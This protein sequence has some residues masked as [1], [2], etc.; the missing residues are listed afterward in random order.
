[1]TISLSYKVEGDG[2]R[3]KKMEGGYEKKDEPWSNDVTF[4]SLV[5]HHSLSCVVWARV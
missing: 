4:S 2:R 1:M 3:W 5:T